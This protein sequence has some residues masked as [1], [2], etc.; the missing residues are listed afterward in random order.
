[1]LSNILDRISVIALTLVVVLLPLFFLPFTNIP[2][3][4]SK[5]L[6]L[7]VG[8][9]VAVISWAAARFSDGKLVLPKSPL[10]LAG[11]GIVAVFFVSALFSTA[12]SFSFFGIMLDVGT[13][14]Y[15]F[16]LFLVMLFA[17]MTIK[18]VIRARMVL[19]GLIASIGVV[20]LFQLFR[21]FHP[22]T[23]S[24]GILGGKTDNLI[25]SWNTFGI[26]SGFFGIISLFIIEFFNVSK[27]F[28]WALGILILLS[29]ILSASVNL[30]L[31]W[32]LLG[33]FS[34]LIFVYKIS[35]TSTYKS[36]ES[37]GTYFP[38][39][40]FAM[41]MV[42]LLFFMSG[43]FV[44][45]LLPDR[46][47][48]SNVEVRPSLSS[49]L[50][51][52]SKS[53]KHDPVLGAGPNRFGESWA[54]YKPDVINSTQ[55]W[56]TAFSSGSGTIPTFMVN[57]GILGILTFVFFFVLLL[58][59]GVQSLFGGIRKGINSDATLYFLAALYLFTASWFYSTGFVVL[60]LAFAFTGIFIGLSYKGKK[61]IELS[62]LT[63]PRK[64]FFFILA[65]IAVML[66]SAGIT[67]K[68]IERFASVPYFSKVFRATTVEEAESAIGKAI[69]L[70]PNDL[71]LRTA[72]QVYTVKLNQLVSKGSA[73]TEDDKVSIQSTFT[74]AE[75]SALMAVQYNSGNSINYQVLGATYNLA[76]SLGVA[77]AYEKAVTAFTNAS[78]LSSNNPGIKLAI[79][80]TYLTQ[81]GH[82]EDA[83]NFASD[84][85]K[86]KPDYV[87]AM[88]VL[89]QIEKSLGNKESALSYAESALTILPG[90]QE[91]INYVNSLRGGSSAP[92][93][94]IDSNSSSE[95]TETNN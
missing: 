50:S 11:L 42:S 68:Y 56:N 84:A 86:L 2:A 55:F 3:E 67:F 34:L 14:W 64:S 48:L 39:Y 81:G 47:G 13:F 30:P 70:N 63:D 89:S 41:I 15:V 28:K 1:M 95:K 5:G 58:V 59:S 25:G 37:K 12:S 82:L 80:R 85:L 21:F 24:L 8:L 62:F 44:G 16:A 53:L 17:S 94:V 78:K 72:N 23:L 18:D 7:V 52:S 93:P 6:L 43:Q 20:L 83:K 88:V 54:S 9:A 75:S 66:L 46:L 36:E 73:L 33:V 45:G 27:A 77:G 19:L 4:T 31:V 91:L 76:G 40:S 26:M 90:N 87:D 10:L 65:L 61:E 35:V 71:Y 22:N 92:A 74:L 29:I 79:A 60:I 57:T 49:M 69:R 51:V 32:E 38:A